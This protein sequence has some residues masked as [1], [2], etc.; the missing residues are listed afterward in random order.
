MRL[1]MT[2]HHDDMRDRNPYMRAAHVLSGGEDARATVR[3]V[4]SCQALATS[5]QTAVLL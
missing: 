4:V 5:S 3:T 2:N 1:Y